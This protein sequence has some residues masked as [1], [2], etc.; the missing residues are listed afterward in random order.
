MRFR[1]PDSTARGGGWQILGSSTA[2]WGGGHPREEDLHTVCMRSASLLHTPE[3]Q[4]SVT[5]GQGPQGGIM[6]TTIQRLA[7]LAVV[8]GGLLV[9]ALSAPAAR[10]NAR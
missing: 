2:V 7:L 9:M 5:R 6:R 3:L 8:M 10:L 4:C 1:V